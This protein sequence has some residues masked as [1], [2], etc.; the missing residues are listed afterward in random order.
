MVSDLSNIKGF[1][2]DFLTLKKLRRTGWQLRGIRECESLADHCFGVALLTMVIADQVTSH[3]IDKDLAIR[4][5]L[6]HELGESRVGDIPFTAL[7]YFPD[8][9]KAELEAVTDLVEPLGQAGKRYLDLFE[10]F[11][12]GNSIEARFVRAI[13]KLEML[14]TARDYERTG[15]QSLDDF[16]N[17]PSTFQCFVE[18]PEVESFARHLAATRKPG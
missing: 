11:E 7:K 14:I 17:N 18:F 2:R 9:A 6:V 12:A 3:E 15:I 10:K 8:K 5:A 16:W 13:D 4:M 1:L